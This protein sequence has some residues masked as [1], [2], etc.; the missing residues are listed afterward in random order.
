MEER[1]HQPLDFKTHL[2][3]QYCGISLA[4]L[5]NYKYEHELIEEAH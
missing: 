2:Q 1:L 3:K 4:I 5:N